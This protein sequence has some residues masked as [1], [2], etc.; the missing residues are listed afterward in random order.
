[1]ASLPLLTYLLLM[2]I[3]QLLFT[4]LQQLLSSLL[5]REYLQ[6]LLPYLQQKLTSLILLALMMLLLLAF[7]HFTV[8]PI[9]YCIYTYF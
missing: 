7:L 5:L 2:A 8:V 3:M 9:T 1:M 4:S 6:L